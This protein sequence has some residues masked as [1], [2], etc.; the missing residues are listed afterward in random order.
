MPVVVPFGF[1]VNTEEPIDK[2]FVVEDL[3]ERNAIDP[4]VRYEGLATY[5][6]A[7]QTKYIL[8]GGITNGHWI[9]DG[10]G[11]SSSTFPELFQESLGF[12][13]NITTEFTM[14]HTPTSQM[15]VMVF[16]NHLLEYGTEY[17]VDLSTKTITFATAPVIGVEVR[18]AYI[19]NNT[20]AKAYGEVLGVGDGVTSS[21]EL[22]FIPSSSMSIMCFGN[23]LY[24]A[25]V[26]FTYDFATNSVNFT[27]PPPIGAV[28]QVFY[29]LSGSGYSNIITQFT[30]E[31]EYVTLDAT[32]V[33]TKQVSLGYTVANP[34]KLVLDVVGLG[35]QIHGV[36]F[37]V[38]G[39]TILWTGGL[40]LDEIAH[41]GMIL[42]VQ[43]LRV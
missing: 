24:S 5:V 30:N 10:G 42:R 28:I 6:K 2:R 12:G 36:D 18:V 22:N 11:G 40:G 19:L 1:D 20:S 8:K 32:N 17:S 29:M 21:Y 43:Y 15:S 14:T 4:F 23:Y 7:E 37:T 35:P 31:T 39:N 9:E 3:T 25:G 26:D 27:T 38:L 33:A 41:L 16:A 13:N 34:S